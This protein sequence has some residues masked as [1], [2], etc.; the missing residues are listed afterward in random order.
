MAYDLEEQEQLAA[1][2][3]WWDKYGTKV[4]TVVLLLALVFAGYNGWS[5]WQRYQ[6]AGAAGAYEDLQNAVAAKDLP[7]AKTAAG[8]LFDQY[9]RTAYAQ[10]G[11]LLSAKA[12]YDSGDVRTAK[13]QLQWVIDRAR[14]EPFKAVA[15]LRLAGIL[16][17]EGATDEALKLVAEPAPAGYEAAWADR[18]GDILFAQKK[19]EEAR[20]AWTLAL[21][22]VG[23]NNGYR[24]IVQLKLDD[25]GPAG[26]GGPATAPAALPAA[27]PAA[28]PAAPAA[29]AAP[30]AP[31]GE[32]K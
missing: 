14:D 10:M 2:K 27:A 18:R 26:G 30:A 12:V 1:L 22:K 20:A 28:A 5:W 29:A 32:K 3:A 9:A 4:T 23:T 25:L 16:L 17:D 13:A 21:E 8:V 31:A 11:G 7:R 15:R 6:A 19:F 24:Q